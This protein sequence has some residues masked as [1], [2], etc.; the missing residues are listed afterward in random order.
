MSNPVKLKPDLYV[1][2]FAEKDTDVSNKRKASWR[3]VL[4]PIEH[5]SIRHDGLKKTWLDILK[6][7]QEIFRYQ[8]PRRFVLGL[9]LRGSTMQL[10]D[11]DWMGATT[12]M[13][14]NIHRNHLLFP[15]TLLSFLWMNDK[16]LDFDSDL[17]AADGKRFVMMNKNGKKEQLIITETLRD[18]VTCI[19]R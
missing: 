18:H 17:M 12:S 11:F 15:K 9:T 8:G 14:F 5:K 1:A 2:M 16:Q 4:I 3:Q 10:E 7:S 19:V 13:P 6:F